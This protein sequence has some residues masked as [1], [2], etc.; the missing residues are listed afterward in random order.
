LGEDAHAASMP[1]LAPPA[2]MQSLLGDS[3]PQ[4]KVV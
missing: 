4:C 1:Q 2:A 3:F